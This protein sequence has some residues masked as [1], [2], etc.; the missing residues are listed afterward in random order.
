MGAL[1]LLLVAVGAFAVGAAGVY[2]FLA[3]S[4]G[5]VRTRAQGNFRPAGSGGTAMTVTG[6]TRR[7]PD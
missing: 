6:C 3:Q 4:A 1:L 2:L 7:T 5:S